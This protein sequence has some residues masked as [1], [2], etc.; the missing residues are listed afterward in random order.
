MT[1][2]YPSRVVYGDVAP[3][4]GQDGT[5]PL[6]VQST[7]FDHRQRAFLERM[8]GRGLEAL[9]SGTIVVIPS[10][11]F[12]DSELRK[13]VGINHYEERMLFV[14]LWLHN[15]DLRIVYVTSEPVD[16]AIVD[17]YLSFLDK[18]EDARERLQLLHLGDPRPRALSAKLLEDDTLLDE[19]K[20]AIKSREDAYILT[21]NVSPWERAISER[22][23]A[24]LYGPSPEAAALGSKS[25]SR[26]I[27]REAN[28][29]VLPGHEDLFSVAE[30]EEA[31]HDLRS[32][33]PELETV[34]LKLNNG[35]SGQG[36]AVIE[37]ADLHSSLPATPTVFCAADETWSTY[38]SK[39]ASE[40]AVVEQ[41]V[42]HRKLISPSV[43]LRVVPGGGV[44]IVSTHDQILGGPDD[45]V[46]MGCRFPAQP[47][48]RKVIMKHG[49]AVAKVLASVGVIGSFGI[50]FVGLPGAGGHVLNLGEINLRMGGTT[51]PFLMARM[52]TGGRLD[53]NTGELVAS[54]QPK[55]YLASDNL[56]SENYRCLTPR[57]A[58]DALERKGIAFNRAR[59]TGATLHLLGALQAF[60]KLGAVCISNSPEEAATLY[61]EVTS[62]LDEAAQ[63]SARN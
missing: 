51:H 38:S 10:I 22:I 25:G 55:S 20:E 54:G 28:V 3:Q 40:G 50:D 6:T 56:K 33:L 32:A 14:L 29:P 63:L 30:L 35:F 16:E 49:L 15:P 39:V 9:E 8:Q 1:S 57:L 37:L 59:G 48:Y 43:Q 45:Q 7:E 36:N 27:A 12:D 2:L 13:I 61:G 23:Q 4:R 26:H 31:I 44:E 34:V 19:L 11:S 62:A 18:P 42:R 53:E 47:E 46:Y 60:G 21:F 17:Y 5:M 24:P 58:I 52:V 41:L